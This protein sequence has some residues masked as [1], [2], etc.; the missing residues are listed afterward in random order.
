MNY[1]K[2]F[3]YTLL[4]V[5][6][7]LLIYIYYRSEV[8]LL[9]NKSNYYQPYYII[10]I[11]LLLFSLISFYLNSQIKLILFIVSISIVS[12]LYIFEG[13]LQAGFFS[14]NSLTNQRAKIAKNQGREFDKRSRY[15][16]YSELKQKNDD[17]TVVVH[18]SQFLNFS[19]D[20]FTLA[21]ISKKKTVH[22]N[23][24]GYFSIYQ[25]DRH[26]FNNPDSEWEKKKIQL[27]LIGDSFVHGSC[28]NQEDTIS[29]N[30]RKKLN[31]QGVINLG[32]KGTGPIIQN[33]ILREY[34]DQLLYSNILWFYFG[35]DIDDLNYELKNEI[36]Y[37]YFSDKK[38]TQ[39]L[40]NKQKEVDLFL[41][42]YLSE[43]LSNKNPFKSFI[44]LSSTRKMIYWKL[45]SISKSKQD[46]N[47]RSREGLNNFRKLALLTKEIAEANDAKIYFIYLP[48]F[49]RYDEKLKL[50]NVGQNYYDQIISIID[51]LEIPIIDIHKELFSLHSSPKKLFPFEIRGHYTPKTYEMISEIILE[52]LE[53]K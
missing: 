49:N 23:E 50:V 13:F 32:Y 52:K 20:I 45:N 28:V 33:A 9:G 2:I 30:L 7:L 38:F 22:C 39:N 1:S 41:E 51:N 29:G 6:S 35:N 46:Y 3:S 14:E 40:A 53:L 34:G 37:N 16:I 24:N 25:S 10:G 48:M 4:I 15:E 44:K 17:T 21:G 5:S 43:T 8:I 12:S 31:D 36:L 47:L 18:P 42:N 11:F 26:G 19:N 27:L